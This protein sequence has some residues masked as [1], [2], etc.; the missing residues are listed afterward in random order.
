MRQMATIRKINDI[1]PIE[2]ADKIEVATVGGWKV[3]VGKGEFKVDDLVVYCEIDSFIPH[4]IAPF[5]SKGK[6][7]REYEGVK[8][9]RLRTVR[10]RGQLSQGLVLPTEPTCSMIE[11][12]LFEG[13]DV[14]APL[15]IQ[16]FEPP[17]PA[18]LSGTVKGMFPSFLRKTDQ[19]RVQ[20]LSGEI[21]QWKEDELTWEITEKLDGSSMTVYYYNG[22]FGVCSRNLNL[23]EDETNT[24]WKVAKQYELKEKLEG[25]GMNIAIQGELIGESIQ[26]NP[27]AIKG[28]DFY[29][30]DMYDMDGGTYCPAHTRHIIAEGL[31]LKHVPVIAENI[32]LAYDDD[33]FELLQKAE[34]TSALK[35]GV[36]R[37]GVVYKCIE[38]PSI[39]FKAV[40]NAFLLKTGG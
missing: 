34:G 12:L 35:D 22:E 7:P 31:G 36:E 11:S 32:A 30:F 21:Q 13:L 18:C 27:Y 20:N 1:S 8:G 39:S 28:Q 15:N 2:G 16:K 40:S 5:L 9:E 10:L 37:E 26:K 24:F 23:K 3:V 4:E 38:D 6:E 25:I 29:V 14:S 19:E 17:I 33:V